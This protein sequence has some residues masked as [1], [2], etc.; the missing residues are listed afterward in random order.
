MWKSGAKRIAMNQ[1]QPNCKAI[2]LAVV[3]AWLAASP[4][5]ATDSADVDAQYSATFKACISTPKA[6]RGMQECDLHEV[7][8][9]DAA[10]DRIFQALLAARPGD[11]VRLQ[12][13]QG[14]WKD[15]KDAQCMVFSR[16]RGSANSLKAMDCF[17]DEAIKRRMELEARFPVV[18]R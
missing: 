6:M 10:L 1:Y 11:R 5:F 16:R 2:A 12:S 18:G 9:Q 15:R 14:A 13:E 17:R 8:Y 7:E 4:A 3:F